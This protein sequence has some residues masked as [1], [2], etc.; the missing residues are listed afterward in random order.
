MCYRVLS[1][2]MSHAFQSVGGNVT[3]A[4]SAAQS[5]QQRQCPP[6]RLVGFKGVVALCA[7]SL[8]L[9]TSLEGR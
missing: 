5:A 8:S 2:L 6:P 9:A 7:A 3:E 1:V 4:L